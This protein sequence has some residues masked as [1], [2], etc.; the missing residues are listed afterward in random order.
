MASSISEQRQYARSCS[1][2]G[3]GLLGMLGSKGKDFGARAAA[4]GALKVGGGWGSGVQSWR[5][6]TS[7]S[8]VC[9]ARPS[10][11]RLATRP[12]QTLHRRWRRVWGRRPPAGTLQLRRSRPPERT[13]AS[14]CGM[15]LPVHCRWWQA[16]WSL[17][18]VEHRLSSGLLCAA[19]CWWLR[20]A[21]ASGRQ[22]GVPVPR[23]RQHAGQMRPVRLA[24][25]L[26]LCTWL[27]HR[28]WLL[29]VAHMSPRPWPQHQCRS[30]PCSCQ[31]RACLFKPG[32]HQPT[33]QW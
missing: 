32:C 26:L 23:W 14:L 21:V 17:P 6:V 25:S 30:H 15:L 4:A 22:L 2:E 28:C 3:T 31:R 1:A 12:L 29:P 27:L 11:P 10:H 9:C 16:C 8:T 5:F 13:S 20:P 18:P 33:H 19:A 7:A 24:S